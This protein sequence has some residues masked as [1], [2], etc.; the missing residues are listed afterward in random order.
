MI[1]KIFKIQIKLDEA[2]RI[3]HNIDTNKI[4]KQ[5]V[6]ALIVEISEFANELA[7]FKYW[8]KNKEINI[9]AVIEEYVD[10]MHFITSLYI[11]IDKR[12]TVSL[13]DCKTGEINSLFANLFK[14]S[15]KL[16]DDISFDNLESLTS[17][18]YSIGKSLDFDW[19]EIEKSYIKKNKINYS[20]IKNNY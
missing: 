14:S 11:F 15:T 6:I 8:K 10:V 16:L 20:R 9:E 1:N 3:A 18:F 7:S 5:K 19:N 13:D 4:K 17:L 12:P 2:I